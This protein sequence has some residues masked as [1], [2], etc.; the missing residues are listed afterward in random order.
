MTVLQTHGTK[1]VI[2]LQGRQGH[3]VGLQREQVD[4][5]HA[6]EAN[7]LGVRRERLGQRLAQHHLEFEPGGIW[8]QLQ[9]LES[10]EGDEHE[11]LAKGEIFQQ[12]LIAAEGTVAL[13][14]QAILV[15]EPLRRK[16]TLEQRAARLVRQAYI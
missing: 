9:L 4:H 13:G 14:P 16:I 1:Q 12:Q 8:C 10:A 6:I 7:V 3:G 5:R 11:F 2:G 15:A